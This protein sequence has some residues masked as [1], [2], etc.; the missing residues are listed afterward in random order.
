MTNHSQTASPSR[1]S[2]SSNT[3]AFFFNCSN[4]PHKPSWT[5]SA[6]ARASETKPSSLDTIPVSLPP[7]TTVTT[8]IYGSLLE[9]SSLLPIRR[10]TVAFL[11]QTVALK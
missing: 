9:P 11:S 8:A 1:Y 3:S 2:T 6:N 10:F 5:L 4:Y 7:F